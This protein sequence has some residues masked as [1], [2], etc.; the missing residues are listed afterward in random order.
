LSESNEIPDKDIREYIQ[1]TNKS[2][3]K[4][5]DDYK[6]LKEEVKKWIEQGR[7]NKSMH[8]W[9]RTSLGTI[10]IFGIDLG[11]IGLWIKSEQ[12][13]TGFLIAIALATLVGMLMVSSYHSESHPKHI[14][15]ST[16]VMRRALT[17]SF[18]VIY[19]VVFPF[20]VFG[21]PV[22]LDNTNDKNSIPS[23]TLEDSSSKILSLNYL[24][25]AE[26][27]TSSEDTEHEESSDS[28]KVGRDVLL[29]HLTKILM[30]ILGF[31]FG[32]KGVKEIVETAKNSKTQTTVA[33]T[34]TTYT[35][36]TP[37]GVEPPKPV[38]PTH[39]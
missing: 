2:I 27:E 10:A 3:P 14:Q 6:H 29:D 23:T 18:V 33:K 30:V 39:H 22:N 20:I 5:A 17:V 7:P 31:Y 36:E 15:G 13:L 28:I 9:I 1:S 11:L 25:V 37:P 8:V 34:P 12:P 32:T 38:K 19:F 24:M 16:G 26:E 35:P 21:D 4:T